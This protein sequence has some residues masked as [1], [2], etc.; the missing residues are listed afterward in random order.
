MLDTFRYLTINSVL[1]TKESTDDRAIHAVVSLAHLKITM[2]PVI[3]K[4]RCQNKL[5]DHVTVN[6]AITEQAAAIWLVPDH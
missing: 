2:F 6:K 1:L 5:L 3:L 4:E